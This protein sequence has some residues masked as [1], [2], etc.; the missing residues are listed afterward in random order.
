MATRLAEHIGD[1][2]ITDREM[3]VLRLIQ[4]GF[5][6]KQ[7]ADQLLV[8]E[9]TVNFHVNNIVDKRQARDRTHAIMIVLRRGL[10]FMWMSITVILTLELAIAEGCAYFD[11]TG[12]S[13]F[14]S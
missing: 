7:I 5:R 13:G 4:S 2:N 9:S 3:Q 10:L 11:P 14:I 1:A 6:N 12:V 8:T